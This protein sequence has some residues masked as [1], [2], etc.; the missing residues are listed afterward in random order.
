[1]FNR[2]VGAGLINTYRYVSLMMH[3]PKSKDINSAN[4]IVSYLSDCEEKKDSLENLVDP[5][6]ETIRKFAY[7]F[8]QDKGTQ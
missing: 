1:M 8:P 6:Q 7:I 2:G 5:I 4:P 3:N